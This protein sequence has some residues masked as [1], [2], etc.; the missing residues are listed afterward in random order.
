M[1]ALEM[2]AVSFFL[3]AASASP[4]D[5]SEELRKENA[6]LKKQFGELNQ[7]VD[8]LNTKLELYETK[9]VPQ[10]PAGA[11][12]AVELMPDG[13]NAVVTA[14]KDTRLSGYVDAGYMVSFN[15]VN[16]AGHAL[17]GT[18]VLGPPAIAPTNPVRGLDNKE[19]S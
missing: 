1:I 19:N 2:V 17:N 11:E 5:S 8:T 14:L 9:Q 16:R 13:D 12:P 3:A 4:Q 6:E 15:H 18:P 7:K 10:R